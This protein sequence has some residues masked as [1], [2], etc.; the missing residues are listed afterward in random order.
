MRFHSFFGCFGV[1]E[2]NRKLGFE[3]GGSSPSSSSPTLAVPAAASNADFPRPLSVQDLEA[4]MDKVKSEVMPWDGSRISMVKQLQEA[5]RNH[6]RV[7][8]MKDMA[9]GNRLVAVKRMPSNWIRAGPQ[10]F[11][12]HYPAASEKPWVDM[13]IV[14]FLNDLSFPFACKFHGVFK[15]IDETF[16]ATSFCTQGDLFVWCD[17][18]SLPRPGEERERHMK[19]ILCQLFTA[20]R[21]LHELGIA[22]RDLSLENIML[23]DSD[24]EVPNVVLIDFGM[25]TLSRSV[26][27]E[28]RGKQSYQA[29]E[30]HTEPQ[31]DAFLA[32]VFAVGVVVF[33]MAAQDYPWTCTKRN[34]CQLFEY[35]NMFGIRRFLEKRKL[36]KGNGEYLIDVFTPA[37]TE[38]VD[39]M[40]QVQ[41]RQRCTLG[42]SCF[43]AEATG[44]SRRSVWD[45]D[46]MQGV[47]PVSPAIGGT[48]RPRSPGRA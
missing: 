48:W 41:H 33:S 30:M 47:R 10:E 42:E 40:L 11:S 22:H 25:A 38:L 4:A 21:Y 12:Q 31:Y 46:W 45:C 44:I 8:L 14:R 43:A 15:S 17:R 29:P 5:I 36:R 16:V 3:K 13:G 27:G 19:P 35:V 24:T 34:A 18:E 39:Y 26:A 20:V 28:V 37:F 2:V 6:G 1:Y 23:T 9:K 32:D 7:D